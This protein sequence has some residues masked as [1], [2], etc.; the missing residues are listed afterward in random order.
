MNCKM[1]RRATWQLINLH[2]NNKS[3]MN[4]RIFGVINRKREGKRLLVVTR[5]R[6][7]N[8]KFTRDKSKK[9][10]VGCNDSEK[11]RTKRR[12]WKEKL[13]DIRSTVGPECCANV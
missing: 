2:R 6:C 5:H 8:A 4:L 3:T 1:S 7:S 13:N 9:F 10:E 12:Q 11:R